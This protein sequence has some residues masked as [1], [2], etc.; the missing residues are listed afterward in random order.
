MTKDELTVIR[1]EAEKH[2]SKLIHLESLVSAARQ[3][4]ARASMLTRASISGQ[5]K[6]ELKQIDEDALYVFKQLQSM[7]EEMRPT[8]IYWRTQHTYALQEY[9][10]N[11]EQNRADQNREILR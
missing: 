5:L 1:T 4:S 2:H 6:T 7:T 10:A 3:T 11:A 8:A 9:N